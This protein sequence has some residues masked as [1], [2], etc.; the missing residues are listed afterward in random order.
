M[1]YGDEVVLKVVI[2]FNIKFPI[3]F[4]LNFGEQAGSFMSSL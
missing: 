4:F 2:L 1:F 3:S